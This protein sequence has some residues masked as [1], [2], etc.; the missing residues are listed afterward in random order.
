MAHIK[1]FS[2]L[3][4]GFML[5]MPFNIAFA[6]DTAAA[7]PAA[8]SI[9]QYE[10][11]SLV[12]WSPDGS[13]L[14]AGEDS[15]LVIVW[16]A[17]TGVEL[18]RF[19]DHHATIFNGGRG[20]W[21]PDGTRIATWSADHT[22]RIW[23]A[24]NG[25][26]LETLMGHTDDIQTL[27]WSPDGTRLLTL[28]IDTT[29]RVWDA[30]SGT[31]QLVF[32]Q[33]MEP[34]MDGEWSPD[35]TRIVTGAEEN[36]AR[37]WDATTGEELF[38][39]GEREPTSA[40]VT[41]G[42]DTSI[43]GVTWSRDG[44]RIA[45]TGTDGAAMIWNAST[46]ERLVVMRT[47]S[48]EDTIPP[49][50][51]DSYW[52]PDD[53]KLILYAFDIPTTVWDTNT[54]DLLYV[55]PGHTDFVVRT[56][57]SLDGSQIMTAGIDGTI[58]FWDATGGA[59]LRVIDTRASV[60]SSE[61]SPDGFLIASTSGTGTVRLWDSGTGREQAFIFS[62]VKTDE[63]SQVTLIYNPA[64]ET[65]DAE[66]TVTMKALANDMNDNGPIVIGK[67]NGLIIDQLQSWEY[68]GVA[69]ETISL[70]I[71]APDFDHL[72]RVF[73]ADNTLVAEG[74]E[75]LLTFTLPANGQ[76]RF[77]VS[78]LD[79]QETN[80]ILDYTLTVTTTRDTATATPGS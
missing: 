1:R 40:E 4:A 25:A 31:Q 41:V 63:E 65:L 13:K 45:V 30:T 19:A 5:V 21:S 26:L 78:S 27:H 43:L 79:P 62:A 59:S 55:L 18:H 70:S 24:A 36:T 54:G 48:D 7:T 60:W 66:I 16:D 8:G 29:A 32:E 15:G 10:G 67:N 14:L 52:S 20:R 56:R 9:P 28:S 11:L 37:V 53:S 72:L 22:A 3:I 33:H 51:I 17:F 39:L 77:E 44:S 69:G 42:R 35:G 58:R 6:Q 12:Q 57:W 46:G 47:S 50:I 80:M 64:R 74:E 76:Y 61:F 75:A 49:Y 71:S 68:S 73:A 2:W 23:D 38:L 34:L